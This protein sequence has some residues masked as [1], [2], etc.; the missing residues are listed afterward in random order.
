MRQS[1]PG[2]NQQAAF[3]HGYGNYSCR[4]PGRHSDLPFSDQEITVVISVESQAHAELTAQFEALISKIENYAGARFRHLD[5][6]ARQ[7][8]IQNTLALCWVRFLALAAQGKHQ[9]EAVVNSTIYW[10]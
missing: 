7:E 2:S 5:P 3:P 10:S 6:E 8:A 9:E 4:H 1:S